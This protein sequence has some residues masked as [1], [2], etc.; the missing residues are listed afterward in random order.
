MTTMQGRGS[1]PSTDSATRAIER[2]AG[3]RAK[4]LEWRNVDGW[5]G[6][7]PGQAFT[8]GVDLLVAG[9][10]WTGRLGRPTRPRVVAAP[11][12]LVR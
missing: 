5:L 7:Q 1:S 3:L 2:L 9:G 12:W 11:E 4:L 6:I 8:A 10:P